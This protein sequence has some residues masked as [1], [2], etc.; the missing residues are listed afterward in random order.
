MTRCAIRAATPH[1]PRRPPGGE[2]GTIPYH[3]TWNE[4]GTFF[5]SHPRDLGETWD[6]LWAWEV[7]FGLA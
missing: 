4:W 7:E 5:M 1:V 3:A 2:G 6:N